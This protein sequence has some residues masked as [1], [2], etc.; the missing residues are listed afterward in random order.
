MKPYVLWKS[1]EIDLPYGF[2]FRIRRLTIV[3]RLSE[4]A[5]VRGDYPQT[6]R[7]VSTM[8]QPLARYVVIGPVEFRLARRWD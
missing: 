5:L 1:H 6:W 4:W 8:D 7:D 3:L 2:S